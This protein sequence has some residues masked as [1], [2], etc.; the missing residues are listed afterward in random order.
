MTDDE[1]LVSSSWLIRVGVGHLSTG[2]KAFHKKGFNHL[3]G[4][5]M[6]KT[7]QQ[8][9]AVRLKQ[10]VRQIVQKQNRSQ[11]GRLSTRPPA[12]GGSSIAPA[13]AAA[14]PKRLSSSAKSGDGERYPSFHSPNPN[15][16]KRARSK[17]P[18]VAAAVP[19]SDRPPLAAAATATSPKRNIIP[20]GREIERSPPKEAAAAANSRECDLS[21]VPEG[22]AKDGNVEA[23]P[24][25]ESK[26][27]II[28]LGAQI[29]R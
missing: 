8:H 18:L 28:P 12:P 1:D 14:D 25:L 20:S 11:L 4:A 22:A 24:E 21:F 19:E 26:K 3:L 13:A 17:S 23:T 27:N 9:G 10:T 2:K 29:P 7:E 16:G 5:L 6:D 15:G